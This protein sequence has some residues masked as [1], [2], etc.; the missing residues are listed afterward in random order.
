[1]LD[2]KKIFINQQARDGSGT[3]CAIEWAKGFKANC[4]IV[5]AT[6]P[7]TATNIE[8]WKKE[9]PE[10]RL[11]IV[12]DYK[13]KSKFD[14]ILKTLYL[15]FVDQWRIRYKFRKIK[16][17][18]TFRTHYGHWN[19]IIE[20]CLKKDRIVSIC[21]DPIKHSGE[22]AYFE[23]AVQ[24]SIKEA[25]DVVVLTESFKSLV[26]KNYG[27]PLDR[28]HF[29]PHGRM[30]MYLEKQNNRHK[31]DYS[32]ENFNFL[33]FGRIEEY[34]GLHVLAK[35]GQIILEKRDDFSIV[36]AGNGD[37]SPYEKDYSKIKNVKIINRFIP[38]EEVGCLF[39]GPN[40]V[41]VVPYID[42]TQSGVIPIAYEYATPIIASNTG[43]LKEQLNN[44]E[45]GLLFDA[46][47]S[48]DLANKMEYIMN[49]IEEFNRQSELMKKFRE[50]LKWDVISKKL[51]DQLFP[52]PCIK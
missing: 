1:M 48:Q 37:F 15:L 23:K 3:V 25:D 34:K 27:I 31:M 13:D 45:I 32:G 44:G 35:A 9:L 26:N 47:D 36:V 39:D 16:F 33:F 22:K 8:E 38:D 5:Y 42:A 50:T 10:E 17:D 41:T 4:C 12:K 40:V 46:G 29:V 18:F 2:K 6:I 20:K 28:I 51:L 30:T 11:F 21:H 7:N 19:S 14:F 49:N 24:N 43:G 52:E